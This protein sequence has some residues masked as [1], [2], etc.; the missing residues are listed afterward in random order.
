MIQVTEAATLNIPPIIYFMAGASNIYPLVTPG[1]P[2]FQATQ[3][4]LVSPL[5]TR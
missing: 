3:I 5:P 2:A 4:Q 1:Y